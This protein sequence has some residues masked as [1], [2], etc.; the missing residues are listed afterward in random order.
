M[1]SRTARCLST[2]A[3]VAG[4]LLAACSSTQQASLPPAATVPDMCKSS[5]PPEEPPCTLQVILYGG[6]AT[7]RKS[8]LGE[9]DGYM[10]KIEDWRGCHTTVLQKNPDLT[11]HDRKEMIASTNYYADY[12]LKN[13]QAN[14]ACINKGSGCSH[15]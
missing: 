8:C 6:T 1:P 4:T 2:L 5:V 3:L 13:A 12:D 15:Y 10:S 9:M 14:V 7:D 11:D